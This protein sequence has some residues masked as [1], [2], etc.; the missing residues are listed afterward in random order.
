MFTLASKLW[1]LYI[2]A[3]FCQTFFTPQEGNF[4]QVNKKD[5]LNNIDSALTL[6]PPGVEEEAALLSKK[7]SL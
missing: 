7:L 6:T 4:D 2:F 3:G 5:S 1:R